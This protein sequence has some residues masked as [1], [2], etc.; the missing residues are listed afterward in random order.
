M[1]LLRCYSPDEALGIGERYGYNVYHEFGY[2]YLT[3][4]GGIVFSKEAVK[5]L[6]ESPYCKC[7]ADDTP[8]DMYLG[9]CMQQLQIPI[10]HAP[11]FHQVC[12]IK[13]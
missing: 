7:P 10:V 2:N 12:V 3:G 8:D 11:Q 1:N 4:G 6:V 13:L 9:I 5:L